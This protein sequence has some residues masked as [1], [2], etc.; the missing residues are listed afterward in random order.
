MKPTAT[1]EPQERLF[2][3]RGLQGILDSRSALNF[4]YLSSIRHSFITPPV[5]AKI[6]TL[7][8]DAFQNTG[9]LRPHP[10]AGYVGLDI[11]A[12]HFSPAIF[13]MISSAA[14]GLASCFAA[15]RI[16]CAASPAKRA[17]M[18][19]AARAGRGSGQAAPFAVR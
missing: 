5:P 8:R 19:S 13:A 1:E 10:Q 7:S 6:Y 14:S 9:E 3:N 17:A 2:Q 15:S 18:L 16:L 4:I 11:S 12:F